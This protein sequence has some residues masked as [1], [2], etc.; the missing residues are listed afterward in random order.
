MHTCISRLTIIGSDNVL[1]PGWCQAI[2]WTNAG[3]LLIGPLRTNFSQI[4]IRIQIFSFKKMHLK[5]DSAK[6]RPFCLGLNVLSDLVWWC[7]DRSGVR[8]CNAHLSHCSLTY[9]W[10]FLKTFSGAIS[11]M[12]NVV[13]WFKFHWS[14]LP[15]IYPDSKV[16]GAHL[17]PTGPRWAPCWPHELCYLGNSL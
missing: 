17:G 1:L 6:W 12:K 5:M 11:S 14:S 13:F 16:H 15:R 10:H 8:T 2:I 4:L 9:W 3:I 7:H